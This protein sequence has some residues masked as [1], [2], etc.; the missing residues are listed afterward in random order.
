M[1]GKVL[2]EKARPREATESKLQL[3]GWHG[4]RPTGLQEKRLVVQPL[5]FP[6]V[7]KEGQVD[8]ALHGNWGPQPSSP[9]YFWKITIRWPLVAAPAA[10]SL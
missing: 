7:A 6:L 9:F 8:L 4:T 1:A 3:G 10:F 5:S 2:G